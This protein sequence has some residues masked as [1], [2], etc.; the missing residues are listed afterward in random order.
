VSQLDYILL[1]KSLRASADGLESVRGDLS[2][3]CKLFKEPRLGTIAAD[4]LDA[5]D[6]CPVVLTLNL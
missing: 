6:D 1:D 5:S 4:G 3:K 2:P